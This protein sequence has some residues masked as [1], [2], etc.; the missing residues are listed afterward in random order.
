MEM[1]KSDLKSG[2]VI[3]MR[4]GVM[5]LLIEKGGALFGVSER[6]IIST[7]NYN[8]DMTCNFSDLDIVKVYNPPIE[9]VLDPSQEWDEY[10]VWSRDDTREITAEEAFRIL[11]EHYGCDVKIVEE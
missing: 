5:L 8:E 9:K 1:V 3:K 2:M 6:V 10:L 7:V 11:K 4:N